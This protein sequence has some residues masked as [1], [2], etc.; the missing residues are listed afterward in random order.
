MEDVEVVE[1]F[2][3]LKTGKEV[4]EA[5]GGE[6]REERREAPCLSRSLRWGLLS[7]RVTKRVEG[8]PNSVMVKPQAQGTLLLKPWSPFT[9]FGSLAS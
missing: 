2:C 6:R 3:E 8:S 4:E 9:G 7:T 5:E 1:S